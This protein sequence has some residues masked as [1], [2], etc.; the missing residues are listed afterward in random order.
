[1]VFKI[2]FQTQTTKKGKRYTIRIVSIGLVISPYT[3]TLSEIRILECN[4]F[5]ALFF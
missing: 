1:M 3:N 4:F 2:C 5:C